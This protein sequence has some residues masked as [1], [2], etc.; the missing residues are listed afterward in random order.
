MDKLKAKAMRLKTEIGELH[1]K[2]VE[3]KEVGITK[4]KESKIYKLALNIVTAQFFLK[5]MLKMK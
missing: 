1:S 4:F 5:E 3:A 2:L